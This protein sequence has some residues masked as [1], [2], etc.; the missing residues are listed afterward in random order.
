MKSEVRSPK[1]ET[2]PKAESRSG[3]VPWAESSARQKR[4]APSRRSSG[5]ECGS[6]L[7]LFRSANDGLN[8]AKAA[9]PSSQAHARP[10]SARD[11]PNGLASLP[12]PDQGAAEDCRTPK[13]WHADRSPSRPPAPVSVFGLRASGFGLR[14]S[15]ALGILAASLLSAAAGSFDIPAWSFDR[16]NVRVFTE[17]WADAG[18][19]VAYGGH[20]PVFAEYDI[21][22]PAAGTYT[23][24][25]QYAAADARPVE[26]ALDGAAVAPVCRAASGSWL[27]SGATWEKSAELKLTAGQHTLRLS[28][29]GAFPH[30]VSVRLEAPEMPEGFAPQRPKARKLP[31]APA[32][33]TPATDPQGAVTALRLAIE[34]LTAS[35]GPRYPR[36][37]DFRQR[38]EALASRLTSNQAD[39]AWATNFS[40]LQREALLANP[41]LDS[42]KLL[43]LKRGFPKPA[44]A[45]SAMGSALGVGTLNAHTSDDTPRQGHWDDELAVLSNLRGEPKLT[46]L[47]KPGSL[48]SLLDPVLHFEAD[49]I[50]FAKTGAQERNWRLWEIGVDGNGLR[51]LTP[52]DGADIGHFD[53]CYLPDGRIIFASTAVYQGLPCE[54]GAQAMTCLY[55]LDPRDSSIRQL[56]FEQ[57]SDWCPTVLPNGRVMYLRWEYTDQSHANSRILF[58]M[59]PDGTDQRELRGSGSWF[60][61][62]FFYARPIP[63]EPHQLVG[64]AGG[65]HGTPRSGR[66]LILDPTQG[67]RDGEGIVQEIPGRGKTVEPIV[68]DRLVDGVWPQF[69]MPWPLSSKYHLVAAKLTPKSLW[70]IYLADVFDNLTLIKE[71]EGA[72]LLWPIALQKTEPPPVIPDRINLATD[73]STVLIT[74]IY[75]GPGLAGVP[76]GTVKK[77][78]VIEY[79]F[80]RRGFGGLYGTLGLDGPWDV[81]RILGTVPVEPDGSVHFKIPAN[82]PLALQP[83]DEKGQAL[84][85]MRS[86][87]V[88]MPGERVSCAG[89]HEPQNEVSLNRPAVAFRR[90]PSTIKP[91]HGPARGF[92]FVREVQPVLDKHCA[93]CH[94]ASPPPEFAAAR[95]ADRLPYLKGDLPLTNWSSQ[96][97]GRWTGGGSFTEAYFQLQRYVRRNGIEG[98]RLMLT[99]LE[100]HF[101]T[102]ELGQLLAA[103]HHGVQL[104]AEAW[105]RLAAWA[106]LNAPFYGTWGEIP[107]FRP[108]QPGGA[109]LAEANRRAEEL[110]RKYVPSGPHP[111]YEAVP[112][113]PP[114]DTTPVVRAGIRHPASGIAQPATPDWPF[115]ASSATAKQQAAA[116]NGKL[117]RTLDLGDG[118]KLEF[119]RV[120]GGKFIAT[121]A[122]GSGAVAEL[123]PFWLAKFEVSNRQFRQFRPEHDSRIEDRH[124][125]QFG[126]LG[127]DANQPDQPAVRVSWEEA[128]AFCEWLSSRIGARVMLPTEAQWE[129]ACRAGSDQPFWFGG[130]DA[131]YSPY[132]N[133]AD[134]M[135]AEF[136]ADTSLDS[137]SAARPMLKP[138][139]YDDWIPRDNRLHDGG[140]IAEPVGRY[141]P[142]P[143]GL[144]DLHGNVAEWTRSG[145]GER[146]IA[147]GGSW[148]SRPEHSTA[149]SR[150]SYTPWQKVFNVGFRVGCEQTG[151][152]HVSRDAQDA[153][154]PTGPG[155][156]QRAGRIARRALTGVQFFTA[157]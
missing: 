12:W 20:S 151:T 8:N 145:Q 1:S 49:R 85:T 4:E 137:Y 23:L 35:F 74:D 5:W 72:A 97:S 82:S 147:R 7:P 57:D 83:L 36:G 157:I 141:K 62:S 76:R 96:L 119:M 52:D 58:H 9:L 100:F 120:P 117:V 65:H 101:S 132:A 66:L 87:F 63:G 130:L 46:P 150:L 156:T 18:P 69:L 116:A 110:R 94:N 47:Y 34:D 139:R 40:V 38:L 153:A 90:P 136:A 81:K 149:S 98:D 140:F 122:D 29:P 68:R 121:A 43:L 142:N 155:G 131:D 79:Y 26:L 133:L 103:G 107:Q 44:A 11:N 104:D 88:G 31:V 70:G 77:L 64:V 144:H 112:K 134:Q 123:S 128:N 148:Y 42:D 3:A 55:L 102:T 146:K 56:T 2:K 109:K 33:T 125:Y 111:D 41:L 10:R 32:A 113:T 114:Y 17:E 37:A 95:L 51:Q 75:Q 86:W 124:G 154:P 73:E 91:W 135:L 138:N 67:R 84:Q 28:R 15:A 21:P 14:L 92:S 50:L 80:S 25:I 152:E 78:R 127:Y 60:P 6:P 105:D 13:R 89:C 126:R 16:G 108:D 93:S 71:V 19:M 48:E 45:R 106:D 143:W 59:N 53:P 27:T 39:A 22:F 54:F 30:V 115:D 118:V 99:P 129:W 61:A 24:S